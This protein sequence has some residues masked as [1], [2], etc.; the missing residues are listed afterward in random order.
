MLRKVREA[1]DMLQP[2]F[3]QELGIHPVTLS[4]F[5]RDVDRINRTVEL[6]VYELATE[7]GVRDVLPP[8][9]LASKRKSK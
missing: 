7:L 6:A 2:E 1:A 8:R 3:A 5:E 4:K 9:K